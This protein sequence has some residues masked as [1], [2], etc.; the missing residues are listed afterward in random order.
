ML[1]EKVCSMLKVLSQQSTERGWDIAEDYPAGAKM[2]LSIYP[3][4]FIGSWN[5]DSGGISLSVTDFLAD[6]LNVRPE[7]E[8]LIEEFTFR[9]H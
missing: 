8:W 6:E 9:F 4:D 1:I 7:F 3:S 5:L 2:K